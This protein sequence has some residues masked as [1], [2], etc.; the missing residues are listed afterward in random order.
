MV[1]AYWM[2]KALVAQAV[3]ETRQQNSE[4]L[5][6][7]HILEGNFELFFVP[8]MALSSGSSSQSRA[9]PTRRKVCSMNL[10]PIYSQTHSNR[11][12]RGPDL[13]GFDPPSAGEP[14]SAEAGTQESF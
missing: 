3:N 1:E 4:I 11:G 8:S 5:Q 6:A 9:Q 7:I 13:E 12:R 2:T 14:V 10:L